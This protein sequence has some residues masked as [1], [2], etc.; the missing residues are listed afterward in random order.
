M[1]DKIMDILETYR[2]NDYID[3]NFSK[4]NLI[5]ILRTEPETIINELISI[6]E[7]LS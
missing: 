7:D 2:Y 6:I 4:Q 1:I 5:D 3:Y